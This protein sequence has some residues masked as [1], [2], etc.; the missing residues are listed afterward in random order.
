MNC[1]GPKACNMSNCSPNNNITPQSY[2][3]GV[4]KA[5]MPNNS[6]ENSQLFQAPMSSDFNQFSS[7][8]NGIY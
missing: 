3:P 6:Y 5:Y 1:C 7:L 2:N 8:S 4:R